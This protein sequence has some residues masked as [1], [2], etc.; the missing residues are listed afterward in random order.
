MHDVHTDTYGRELHEGDQVY[1]L[2]FFPPNVGRV[3]GFTGPDGDVDDYGR[4]VGIPSHV[5]V[6]LNGRE[7]AIRT[8]WRGDYY[9]VDAPWEAEDLAAVLS[10]ATE[11]DEG[12]L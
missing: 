12:A 1:C 3:I 10:M 8:N 11:L 9:N 5:L 4:T 2:D 6:S 7:E